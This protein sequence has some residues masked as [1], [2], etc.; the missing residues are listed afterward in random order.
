MPSFLATTARVSAAQALLDRGW[1]KAPQPHTGEDDE[2]IRVTGP[3]SQRPRGQGP[4][5][6]CKARVNPAAAASLSAANWQRKCETKAARLS[7]PSVVP[8]VL[9][10]LDAKSVRT[11]ALISMAYVFKS[12]MDNCLGSSR[13]KK[14][15]DEPALWP[16]WGKQR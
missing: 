14:L 15:D 11:T 5:G 7:G 3:T 2:D 16:L 6:Q 12:V 10:R 4:N 13:S 9:F 8:V 1:G